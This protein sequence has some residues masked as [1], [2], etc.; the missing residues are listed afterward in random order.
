M[1]QAEHRA[2]RSLYDFAVLLTGQVKFIRAW[3]RMQCRAALVLCYFGEP[4]CNLPAL[5]PTA[6]WTVMACCRVHDRLL[7]SD[8]HFGGR[9][10]SDF[11]Q[12]FGLTDVDRER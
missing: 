10:Q 7:R 9:G 5:F 4:A 11:K 1:Q 2:P 3:R 8:Q 12:F 6:A